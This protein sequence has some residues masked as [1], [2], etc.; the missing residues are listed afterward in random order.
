MGIMNKIRN[1][2][3]KKKLYIAIGIV[4][5]IAIVV[6]SILFIRS[7]NNNEP[8]LDE[9][10]SDK[11]SAYQ[12]DLADSLSTLS[13]NEKVADYLLNW[14]SNKDIKA[15]KDVNGNVIF[16]LKA[17]SKDYKKNAPAVIACEYD[18]ANLEEYLEP[19]A[20]A[21]TV[22]KNA[23][24]HG[25]FKIIF[26]PR[27]DNE[28]KGAESLSA[29]YLTEDTQ[30]FMLGAS[31]ASK[32]S[33]I[34]G[35][36]KQFLIKDSLKTTTPS[37]DKA[38]KITIKHAPVRDAGYA[39]NPIKTLGNLLANFK[40]TSLLFEL[41]SF[42][43]GKNADAM[44]S[45]ASVTVVI[46]S[47]DEEKFVSKM[48]RAIEKFNDKYA[49]DYPEIEYTYKEVEI[50]DSV[51]T[52]TETENIVS[53]MYTALNGVYYK[54]DDGNVEAV[55]NIGR[56]ST[57]NKSL[58][59]LVSAMSSSDELL[60]EIRDA[61]KTIAGL[62]N[63][64]SSTVRSYKVYDGGD[65]TATLLA[66]F[67]NSF[68]A[69]TGDSEMIVEPAVETTPCSVFCES[70]S[71]PAMLYCGITEKTKEKFAGSLITF[72]ENIGDI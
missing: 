19:L 11:L 25:A 36:Y 17:S 5:I 28:M 23:K 61:Y 40:S 49:G 50:P 9:I 18:S 26:L 57:K 3:N 34:T 59:I 58:S 65:N 6:G 69:F 31:S 24:N 37:Y 22:A 46:N 56:M 39:V 12:T 29:E 55:T 8:T 62:C 38:Y 64:K 43:G 41:S 10:V 70:N 4:L 60:E 54:G 27:E 51:F 20:T 42:N 52:K 30:L 32:V 71:S 45:R 7:N 63:V 53:L 68:I 21:L 67:E 14:A 35:G 72:L 13:S 16:S 15:E 33:T 47:S 2:T 44:P 66:Q 48:D 1:L